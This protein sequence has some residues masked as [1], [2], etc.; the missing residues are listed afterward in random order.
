[1]SQV[2]LQTGEIKSLKEAL[3]RLKQEMKI[4]DE[5][6]APLQRE[7]QDLQERVSKLKTRLKGKTMLHGGKHVIWDA[8]AVEATKFKVYLN[9]INDKDNVA[10]TARSRCTVVNET[11]AKK[12]SEW[13]QNAID[14]LN[15]VPTA[16]LQTIGVN[17][18]TVLIIWARRIIAKHNLLKS[19]QNKAM[20]ME[21]NI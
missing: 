10:T 9:F 12:P 7:N 1:M 21:H 16:D 13:A 3:E 6:M 4:K 2:S 20:K 8:I 18:R 14:L 11:L 19:I 17:D 5:N 15:S